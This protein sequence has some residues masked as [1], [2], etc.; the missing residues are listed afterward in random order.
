MGIDL[1]ICG[2]GWFYEILQFLTSW[3]YVSVALGEPTRNTPHE[4]MFCPVIFQRRENGR[5]FPAKIG[6]DRYGW[7]E[8]D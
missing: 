6:C 1:G 3:G 8:T 4:I 5:T 7:N 2:Q